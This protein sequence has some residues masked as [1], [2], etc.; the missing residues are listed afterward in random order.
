M[1]IKRGDTLYIK[2]Q[3]K[4]FQNEYMSQVLKSAGEKLYI[5]IPYEKKKPV[6][7]GVGTPL[8]IRIKGHNYQGEIL[9]RDLK[10]GFFVISKP[11][12]KGKKKK[13]GQVIA[14]TSGK[15]GV[16]KSTI[17][18]NLGILLS[19]AGERVS[20]VDADL[21]TANL[22]I[23]LK[24]STDY[25]LSHVV[26]GEKSILEIA[27][28]GPGGILLIPGGSGLVELTK[29]KEEQ[30]LKISKSFAYLEEYSDYIFFDTSA[31][32]GENIT[33][34][35]LA[36]DQIVVITTPEPHSITDAYAII[37]VVT[38]MRRDLKIGLLI[39]QV[40]KER[41]GQAIGE[42]MQRVIKKY[43]SLQVEYCGSIQ[44][45]LYVKK[46]IKRQ[47]PFVLKYPTCK[48]SSDMKAL[49]PFFLEKTP[50]EQKREAIPKKREE[51]PP[52]IQRLKDLFFLSSS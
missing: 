26:R 41:E 39:N 48:A 2:P 46:A 4:Y 21:G 36:A 50:R 29:L 27:K 33:H 22:D 31:G 40:E 25:N 9:A 28:E 37:K 51:R 10:E 13:R 23:L 12:E 34:F 35:L 19:L 30:L 11:A 42:R 14:I 15:G 7:V 52:F 1:E 8:K 18:A 24:I 45:D 38:E 20:I 44:E 6:F 3:N 5:T 32:L 49:L 43:L 16:G 47:E 17:L